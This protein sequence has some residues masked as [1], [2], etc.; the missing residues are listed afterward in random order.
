MTRAAIVATG[1]TIREWK[2]RH[3]FDELLEACSLNRTGHMADGFCQSLVF[4]LSIDKK[5]KP[6]ELRLS[7]LAV[8]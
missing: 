4:P 1:E 2:A 3:W 8:L 5:L 6:A 7:D